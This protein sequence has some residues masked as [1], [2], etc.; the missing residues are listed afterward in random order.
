MYC[1]YFGTHCFTNKTVE[2]RQQNCCDIWVK[3]FRLWKTMGQNI[4]QK[5]YTNTFMAVENRNR[6]I[7]FAM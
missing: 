4:M 5:K 3:I 6:K 7:E 2:I 1:L